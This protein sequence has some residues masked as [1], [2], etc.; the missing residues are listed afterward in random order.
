MTDLH[1]KELSG[2]TDKRS[3]DY[4]DKRTNQYFCIAF[5]LGKAKVIGGYDKSAADQNPDFK[6][7][8]SMKIWGNYFDRPTQKR[9]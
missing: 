5:E 3:G 1:R 7:F 6:K 9:A 8:A 4:Y 2:I